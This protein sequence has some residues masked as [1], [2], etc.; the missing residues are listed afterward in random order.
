MRKTISIKQKVSAEYFI[1]T[2][3]MARRIEI[4]ESILK[5]SKSIALIIN[6]FETAGRGSLPE[7]VITRRGKPLKTIS[8]RA[9]D[10]IDPFVRSQVGYRADPEE[11]L[12]VHMPNRGGKT[13][14]SALSPGEIS[15]LPKL[16]REGH[17][18]IDG[19]LR[20]K[21]TELGR[22]VARGA[23]KMYPEFWWRKQ[24]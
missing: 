20:V 6:A 16:A 9:L 14:I 17:V 23:K 8:L 19:N 2:L 10:P 5:Q 3:G 7:I 21:L 12:L 24:G 11:R 22:A 4:P 18:E 13:Q 1:Q 15:L